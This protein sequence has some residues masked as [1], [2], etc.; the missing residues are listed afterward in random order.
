MNKRDGVQL[1]SQIGQEGLV[2]GTGSVQRPLATPRQSLSQL[3]C[4]RQT[5][6]TGQQVEIAG[7]QST[8]LLDHL[9]A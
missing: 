7:C 9:Y 3:A 5:A 4:V 2:A 8:E 6:H 1:P